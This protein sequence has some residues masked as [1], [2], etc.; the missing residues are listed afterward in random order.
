MQKY[1]GIFEFQGQRIPNT[2]VKNGA[3]IFLQN[4]F[5]DVQTNMPAAYYLGLTDATYTYDSADLSDIAAGEPTGNGYARQL[6][7]RND[8]DWD[9]AEVNGLMRARSK[10]VTF[11]ASANWDVA[12]SRMFLCN[13]ASGTSGFVFALSGALLTPAT[14]LSGDGPSVR[15]EFWNRI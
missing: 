7:T 5:Q 4:L 8:T 12:W 6:L 14:V 2:I 15:Y 10:L 13:Q 3:E 1:G 9:V 11:T